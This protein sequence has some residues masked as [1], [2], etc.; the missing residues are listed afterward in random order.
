MRIAE[1]RKL[2][3]FKLFQKMAMAT[4]EAEIHKEQVE[5]QEQ[6]ETQENV[7]TQEVIKD[8]DPDLTDFKEIKDGDTVRYVCNICEKKLGTFKGFRS[9]IRMTHIK[10]TTEGGPQNTTT[11]KRKTA[12][13]FFEED[14]ETEKKQKLEDESHDDTEDFLKEIETYWDKPKESENENDDEND[15][16]EN[17]VQDD[18]PFSQEFTMAPTQQTSDVKT[19]EE[20]KVMIDLL[21]QEVE[22]A[23]ANSAEEKAKIESLEETIKTKDELIDIGRGTINSLEADKLRQVNAVAAC[24]IKRSKDK[25]CKT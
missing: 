17:M 10:K 20:A 5:P 23:K 15:T 2:Y 8:P 16:N 25:N 9:H 18:F 13:E 1:L 3:K 6:V 24:K 21:K 4:V 19:L 14:T 12:S 11:K 22:V 7:K